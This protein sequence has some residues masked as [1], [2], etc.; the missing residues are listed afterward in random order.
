MNLMFKAFT[1]VVLLVAGS[2]LGKKTLDQA[3]KKL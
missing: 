2:T 1:S 3:K